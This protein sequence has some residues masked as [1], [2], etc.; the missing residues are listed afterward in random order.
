M[1]F[2]IFHL[3]WN[4]D[5][6]QTKVSVSNQIL[7][8]NAYQLALYFAH[9]GAN[10]LSY[11]WHFFKERGDFLETRPHATS[12]AYY[13]IG[14]YSPDFCFNTDAM[15]DVLRVRLKIKTAHLCCLFFI[16]KLRVFSK[17]CFTQKARENVC[18]SS[19]NHWLCW[20][21]PGRDCAGT[22]RDSHAESLTSLLEIDVPHLLLHLCLCSWV[23]RSKAPEKR[24]KE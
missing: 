3:L 14:K 7:P 9:C 15:E 8:D 24:G 12:I 2:C 10:L 21:Q 13:R 5:T 23:G 11:Q 20:V 17:V 4:G 22:I 1:R 19:M 16:Y 18:K 6:M